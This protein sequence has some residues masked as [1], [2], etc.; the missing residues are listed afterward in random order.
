MMRFRPSRSA[1]DRDRA[2]ELAQHMALAVD[3]LVA[4]G[5]P[6]DEARRQVRLRF[7]NPRVK[8]EEV[9]EMNRLPIPD[10]LSQDVRYALRVLR[11]TP[12]F[13]LTALL[14]LALV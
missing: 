4:R 7:G 6:V 9:D 8:Q 1:R 10:V 13:T 2:E 3:E 11:R 14:T 12:A 5:I